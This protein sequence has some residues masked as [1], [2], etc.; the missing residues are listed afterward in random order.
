MHTAREVF[1]LNLDG[2]YLQRKY[3]AYRTQTTLLILLSAL[4]GAAG[5]IHD[6][7]LDPAAARDLVWARVAYAWMLIPAYGVWRTSNHRFAAL[8]V[9][10]SMTLAQIH[11]LTILRSLD[12][13]LTTAVASFVFYPLLVVLLSLGFSLF[14][15]WTALAL[16]TA[17]PFVLAWAGWFADFPYQLYG[18]II[19]P[20]SVFLALICVAFA[21][22]H[23]RRHQLEIALENASNTDPLT[24]AANRRHFT[25]LLQ[26]ETSRFLRLFSP[27]TLLMLDIDHFKR[28]NDTFGHPTGDR[29]IQALANICSA[30]SREVDVVARLGGEEFAV[31]MPGTGSDGAWHLAER[32]RV[33]VQELRMLSDGG[34]AFQWTVSI[35]I[36]SLPMPAPAAI[37]AAGLGEQLMAQADAALYE[38]KSAGR[39][40][41]APL[42]SPA[43]SC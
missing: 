39:N 7:N 41:I 33:Q 24:G 6:Y 19:W 20:T 32:I 5:W 36:A 38:A 12:G 29:A 43:G 23:H 25:L 14:V 31:L 27:C 4:M 9:L 10:G 11:D 17:T 3:L 37:T 16:V 26:R 30:N 28:I 21:F 1:W 42:A 35:G 15:N 40:R 34:Q 8:L 2:D 13:I 18:M 22:G